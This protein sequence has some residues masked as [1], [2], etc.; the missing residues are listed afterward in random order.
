MQQ[1][2]HLL[3][4]IALGGSHVESSWAKKSKHLIIIKERTPT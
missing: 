4:S 3:V 1:N 2:F